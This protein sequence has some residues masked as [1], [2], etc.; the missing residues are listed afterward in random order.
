MGSF[1]TAALQLLANIFGYSKQRSEQKN[2]EDVVKG[3]VAQNEVEQ[4]DALAKAVAKRDVD[5]IRKELS[6]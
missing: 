6:E 2:R 4:Q 1:V 3:Q 5:A